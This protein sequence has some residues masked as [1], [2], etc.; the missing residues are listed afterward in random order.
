MKKY[1]QL[2]QKQR[3]TIECMIKIGHSQKDIASV[4]GVDKSTI[5]RE[6]K[7]NV[8]KR[9]QYAKVYNST[10]AQH[11]AIKREQEKPKRIGISIHH[12][13]YIR[14][15]LKEERWSPEYISKRGS[16]ELGQFVSHETIYQYIW[17]CKH[18]HERKYKEDKELHK[19]LK[20]HGRRKKRKNINDN[21]GCIANR[22]PMSKRPK[23]ANQRKRKGDYEVDLMM[24]KNRKPA[25]I[26]MTDRKLRL[27]ELIK[28][29]NK[30]AKYISNKIIER[31]KAKSIKI[32]TMTFDNGLEFADHEKIAKALVLKTYFTR[33]YTSQDKGSVENRIGVVRRFLPKG[34]DISKIH[35]NTI[36]SIE[37]KI[38]N[39]PLRIFD[40]LTPNEKNKLIKK[41]ALVT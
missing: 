36:R 40:Y 35:H 11:K 23:I 2:C 14:K 25:L 1:K 33:P 9:G 30:T 21:R 15:K 39:R 17:R 24:G 41:V 3:Y 28:I 31:V 22:I 34:T 32:H 20:H 7:R 26:V 18:S 16:L 6:L 8:N 37:N 29:D 4:I 12:L 38:N 19:Y 10:R 13:R 27:T 5:S